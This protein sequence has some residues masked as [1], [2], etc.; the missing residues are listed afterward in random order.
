MTTSTTTTSIN[1]IS[2]TL[3]TILN[4]SNTNK[5]K[6]SKAELEANKAMILGYK[7]EYTQGATE[8]ALKARTKSAFQHD[9]CNVIKGLSVLTADNKEAKEMIEKEERL[10]DLDMLATTIRLELANAQKSFLT[11]GRCLVEANESIK[12]NGGN[13]KE[14]LDWAND[15]CEI[16]KAQAYKLMKVYKDFG[17]SSDFNGVAMRVLYALTG[18]TTEQVESARELAKEGKLDTQALDGI[19]MKE[20]PKKE[21]APADGLPLNGKPTVKGETVLDRDHNHEDNTQAMTNDQLA[22]KEISDAMDNMTPAEI[23]MMVGLEDTESNESTTDSTTDSSDSTTDSTTDNTVEALNDTIKELNKTVADLQAQLAQA[24]AHNVKA[25][26]P[27]LPQ[28]DSPCMATVIGLEADNAG[29]KIKINKAYRALASIYTK[30]SSP[31]SA[32]KLLTARTALL[33]AIK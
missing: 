2:V 24:Q 3:A 14:F 10:E 31:E 5:L 12:A 19:M 8:S 22:D 26:M 25:S 13:Q 20:A 33:S 7:C 9:L 18:A 30:D 27:A 23:K 32:H 29:D 21:T 15:H 11:V 16:K 28:F 17:D 1:S 4:D 6:D